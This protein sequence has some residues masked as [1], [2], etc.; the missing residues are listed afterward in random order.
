M[1]RRRKAK[2]QPTTFL[3]P[4]LLIWIF[5]GEVKGDERRNLKNQPFLLQK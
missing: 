2:A 4:V 3:I 5:Y 1:L